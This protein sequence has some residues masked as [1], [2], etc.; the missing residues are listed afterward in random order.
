MTQEVIE[1][2]SKEQIELQDKIQKLVSF[3]YVKVCRVSGD[4]LYRLKRQLRTM[5]E[6]DQILDERLYED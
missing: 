3:L 5:I 2:V 6:Y 1:R 4:E